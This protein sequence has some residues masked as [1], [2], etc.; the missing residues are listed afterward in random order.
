LPSQRARLLTLTLLSYAVIQIIFPAAAS[1]PPVPARAAFSPL[2]NAGRETLSINPTLSGD[3]RRVAFETT[4][5]LHGPEQRAG[6]HAVL[7]GC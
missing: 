3:G 7:M 4:S 6:F 5:P 2:L 1:P